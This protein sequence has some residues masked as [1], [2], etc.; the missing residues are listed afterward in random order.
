MF[1]ITFVMLKE[2]RKLTSEFC[3]D[4]NIQF[5]GKQASYSLSLIML[6]VAAVVPVADF[7]RKEFLVSH[8]T[9]FE[10][11]LP[12]LGCQQRHESLV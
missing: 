6:G 10:F 5:G 7:Y 11:I 1:L 12:R 3:L 9:G 4:S 2:N 8:P